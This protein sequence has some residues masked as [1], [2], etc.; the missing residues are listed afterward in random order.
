MSVLN[1]AGSK[2]NLRAILKLNV[3]NLED[4]K[5]AYA[6]IKVMN[7]APRKS[8]E[9]VLT[10]INSLDPIPVFKTMPMHWYVGIFLLLMI[11]CQG[12]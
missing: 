11:G 3:M 2:L 9:D 1:W 10:I 5:P 8:S 6:L 12:G 7:D 4:L